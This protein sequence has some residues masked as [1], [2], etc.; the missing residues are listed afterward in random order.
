MF[1]NYVPIAVCKLSHN[2]FI[3]LEVFTISYP[4]S[5]FSIFY[6]LQYNLGI[7]EKYIIRLHTRTQ[8]TYTQE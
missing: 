4:I 3:R 1:H 6:L 8:T 5:V 2:Q 7:K